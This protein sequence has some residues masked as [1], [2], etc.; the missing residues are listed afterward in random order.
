VSTFLR[1]YGAPDTGTLMAVKQQPVP[2]NPAITSLRGPRHS[3][4][5]SG[6]RCDHLRLM[7]ATI[8]LNAAVIVF[9]LMPTP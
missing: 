8:E 5:V 4:G 1:D 2:G 7:A 3:A 9:W 6:Y